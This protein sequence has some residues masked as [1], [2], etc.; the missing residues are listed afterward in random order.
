MLVRGLG[1]AKTY[2]GSWRVPGRGERAR[3][4]RENDAHGFGCKPRWRCH[5]RD[6]A[7]SRKNTARRRGGP[8][9]FCV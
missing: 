7:L 9:S 1:H 2:R 5:A 3:V 8:R 6:R 4:R